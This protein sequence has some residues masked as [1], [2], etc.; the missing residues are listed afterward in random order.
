MFV[1]A[2]PDDESFGPGGTLAKYAAAGAKVV[3]ACATRG[4]AGTVDRR[5]ARASATVAEMR[6]A[7][8]EC[9]GRE[10]GLAAV[11]PLGYRDSGMPG[12]ADGLHPRA[13]V[14]APLD[15]VVGDV[16]RAI[17]ESRPQVVITFDPI[18]GYRHPDHIVIHRA[19]EQAF[20]AS[21]QGTDSPQRLYYWLPR[22][23][24]LRAVV[25]L[26]RL[27]GRDPARVG[28]NRDVDLAE[29]ASV[30]F[31][32]HARISLSRAAIA[33][34]Y[35]ALACHRSQLAG[36]ATLRRI[37]WLLA[38]TLASDELFMRAYPAPTPA[39]LPE[40]DLFEAVR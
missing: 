21:R 10:L 19:T 13:L 24:R 35:A 37:T 7:E 20:H 28:R 11:V 5:Y 4:E 9:A 38:R 14:K 26:L 39:E 27:L 30:E 8:L 22:R 15:E 2:H 6:W 34:K 40:T 1:G 25:R 17:R 29:A 16:T 18:G 3:Y 33:R 23:Q 31:P 36:S 32:V 12:A